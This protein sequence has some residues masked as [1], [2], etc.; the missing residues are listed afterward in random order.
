MDS[1]ADV[2]V[3]ARQTPLGYRSD[4]KRTVKK[5]ISILFFDQIIVV[6]GQGI[7]GKIPGFGSGWI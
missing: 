7:H 4:T 3:R 2:E 5:K 1:G 6:L